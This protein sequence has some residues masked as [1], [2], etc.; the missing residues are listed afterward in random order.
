VAQWRRRPA[1][2]KRLSPSTFGEIENVM[3]MAKKKQPATVNL[4]QQPPASAFW[5]FENESENTVAKK[6]GEG[7]E[8]T[9]LMAKSGSC[10]R[11]GDGVT[12]SISLAKYHLISSILYGEKLKAGEACNAFN[13]VKS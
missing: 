1:W 9:A 8:K 10:R 5:L 12:L 4:R 6:A 3:S 2:R 13:G 11:S 7:E